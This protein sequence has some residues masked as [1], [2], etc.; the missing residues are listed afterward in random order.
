MCHSN[1]K[2]NNPD[3]DPKKTGTL[4]TTLPNIHT[5]A[6]SCHEAPI[7]LLFKKGWPQAGVVINILI[8]NKKMT[9]INGIKIKDHFVYN[10]PKNKDLLGF[11]RKNRKAGNLA[12]I[13]FWLQ[14]RNKLFH[15]LD[16]DRQRVIGNYIVDF[17][18]R[19][20]GLVV[21]IDGGSH[22]EKFDYDKQRDSFFEGLGLTVFHTTD[23]DVLQHVDLV[24]VD[25]RR[26]IIKYCEHEDERL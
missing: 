18:V 14:V 20:L 2:S 22:N 5:V 11:A 23:Y 13:A 1:N 17:Y 25:L 6:L 7:P 12:E 10:L 21:E 3:D 9:I 16:F 8:P 26:F 15:G 4:E 24:L 19:R